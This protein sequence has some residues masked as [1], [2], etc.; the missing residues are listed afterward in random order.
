MNKLALSVPEVAEL[1]GLN[2]RTIYKMCNAGEIPCKRIGEKKTR[3]IIS[4]KSLEEWL[5]KEDNN[6]DCY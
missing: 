5:N 3:I 4:R 1:L 6:D 2:A